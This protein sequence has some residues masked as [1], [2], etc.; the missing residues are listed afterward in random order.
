MMKW[1]FLAGFG[2]GAAMGML[3]APKRGAELRHD[4]KDFVREKHEQRRIRQEPE[5]EQSRQNVAPAVSPAREER[6]E[7]KIIPVAINDTRKRVDPV[8]EDISQSVDRIM[9]Q[10]SDVGD[11]IVDNSRRETDAA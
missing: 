2:A 9:A 3:V 4:M 8:L 5:V 6:E 10:A 7:E 1:T 11:R